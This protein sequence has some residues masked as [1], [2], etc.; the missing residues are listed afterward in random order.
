MNNLQ[1][2]NVAGLSVAND[3][4]F[5]LFGGMNVLVMTVEPVFM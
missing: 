4:S 3:K 1:T 2:V 5:T